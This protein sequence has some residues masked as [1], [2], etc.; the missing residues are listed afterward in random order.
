MGVIDYK[1]HGWSE[2]LSSDKVDTVFDFAPSGYSSGGS[3]HKAK[4]VLKPMGSFVTISSLGLEEDA[5]GTNFKYSMVVRQPSAKKLAELAQLVDQGKLRPVV[6]KVYSF[7]EA[8]SAF[9]HL[10]SG[11]AVG[12]LVLSIP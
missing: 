9:E 10:M 12:K 11:R 6:E 8:L 7:G 3:A 1:E 4:R 2:K 5:K